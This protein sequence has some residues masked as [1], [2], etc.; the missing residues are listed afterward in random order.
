M[1][2]IQEPSLPYDK[3]YHGLMASSE[4]GRGLFVALISDYLS[5]LLISKIG[6]LTDTSD[7]QTQAVMAVFVAELKTKIKTSLTSATSQLT[8]DLKAYSP[9]P[10]EVLASKSDLLYSYFVRQAGLCAQAL[11]LPSASLQDHLQDAAGFKKDLSTYYIQQ[12]VLLD[13]T[14]YSETHKQMQ[15]LFGTYEQQLQI[16]EAVKELSGIVVATFESIMDYD[17]QNKATLSADSDNYKL[18]AAITQTLSLKIQTIADSTYEFLQALPQFEIS[19]VLQ[20]PLTQRLGVQKSLEK[21]QANL[22]KKILSFKKEAILFEISTFN[23]LL[24]HSIEKLKQ[25]KDIERDIDILMY[26]QVVEEAN[27]MINTSLS[28]YGISAICPKPGTLFNGKEHE[29]MMMD[30]GPGLTKGQIIRVTNIGY[31]YADQILTRANVIV[32]K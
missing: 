30:T 27:S 13:E 8:T 17:T 7:S 25:A 20:Q 18:V 16:A 3:I 12:H 24:T 26:I 6:L 14:T 32:A 9:F 19:A 28:T 2:H 31:R 10:A 11:D 21:N 5:E 4:A 23:E 15:Q 22:T 1:A 29:V